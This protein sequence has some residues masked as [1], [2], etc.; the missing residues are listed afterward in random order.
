MLQVSSMVNRGQA[1]RQT[2]YILI[3]EDNSRLRSV[4]ARYIMLHCEALQ[5]SCALY[6][7]GTEGQPRLTYFQHSN[8]DAPSQAEV[9]VPDFAV[10]EADSPRRALNW[11]KQTPVKQLTIISDVMMP[12]DTQ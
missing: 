1:V 6:H 2:N 7:I 3:V 8:A 5:Q 12:S 11:L 9:L 10:F 4:L